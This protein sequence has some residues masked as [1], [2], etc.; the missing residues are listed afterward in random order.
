MTNSEWRISGKM[1]LGSWSK[2]WDRSIHSWRRAEHSESTKAKKKRALMH[3]KSNA[4]TLLLTIA[5]RGFLVI[6]LDVVDAIVIALSLFSSLF[7]TNNYGNNS[8]WIFIFSVFLCEYIW[9]F[10]GNRIYNFL[11]PSYP[12]RRRR[13]HRYCSVIIFISFYTNN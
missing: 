3:K 4:D 9:G 6:L 5:F 1:R 7:Y 10:N 13:C 11:V 8:F 12:P 2:E